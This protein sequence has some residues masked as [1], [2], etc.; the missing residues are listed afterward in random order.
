M[1]RVLYQTSDNDSIDIGEQLSSLVTS[2]KLGF[3][4]DITI[5]EDIIN[6]DIINQDIIN[7]DIAPVYLDVH[8]A[9]PLSL[10]ANELLTNAFKHAFL[11]ASSEDTLTVCLQ[12]QAG[13]V[14]L[15][16]KDNGVGLAD[17]YP[18]DHLGMVI[19][20]SL[21]QQIDATFT[22]ENAPEGGCLARV[23][24]RQVHK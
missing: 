7:E 15:E 8:Q 6:Q 18:K 24:F 12:Q 23:S 4:A 22:L 21:A 1:H 16:I 5:N 19:V 9:I 13:T 2:L 10:I 20:E 3:R 17:D 14:T 11:E